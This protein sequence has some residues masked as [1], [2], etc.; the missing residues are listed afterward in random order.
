M[1][2]TRE[3]WPRRRGEIEPH[4][5]A[6]Q[7]AQA[8]CARRPRRRRRR[9][10]AGPGRCPGTA[11]RPDGRHQRLDQAWACS[12]AMASPKAATPGSTILSAAASSAGVVISRH[13]PR[14]A[15]GPSGRFAG[16]PCRSQRLRSWTHAIP[17]PDDS[18]SDRGTNR[19]G[20]GTT[21][22][23]TRRSQRGGSWFFRRYPCCSPPD[24]SRPSRTSRCSW[25]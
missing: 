21:P 23:S 2:G 1:C 4:D 22:S 12:W 7:D 20:I 13:R 16:C 19:A 10:F 14:P 18:A 25:R 8:L 15:R 6:G 3:R 11:C 9:A 5:L 17:E 24:D